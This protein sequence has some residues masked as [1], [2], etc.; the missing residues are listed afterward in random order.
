[1]PMT[2]IS[3]NQR[4]IDEFHA[5][6]GR[7]VG[8][9]QDNLLLMTAKGAKSGDAIT[10]PLVCRKV[11]DNYVVVASKGGAPEHPKWYGNLKAGPV[12]DLEVPAD[13]GTEHLQARARPVEG[14]EEHDRLYALMTEVWPG[15]A[16]YQKKT[17]RK[18]PV[19]VLEPIG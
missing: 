5:K 10:T 3:W 16:D 11:G 2:A 13:S 1:M 4:T 17:S 8:P 6:Q 15:F 14:G 18:I 12:V 19:V 7:G 9:W